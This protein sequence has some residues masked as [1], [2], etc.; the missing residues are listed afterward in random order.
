[1]IQL[2]GYMDSPFVRRVAISL[3]F[4]GIAYEHRE[5]SIFRDFDEFR[6]INPLVKV[7]TLVL[8]N[9]QVLVDS[10][11][12]IDHLEKHV[13]GRSLMPGNATDHLKATQYIGA[14]LVAM[15]KLAGLI[16]ETSHRPPGLQHQ[17][18]IDRLRTQLSGAIGLMETSVKNRKGKWLLGNET[19]QADITTAVAWRFS[20]HIE[21]SHID[22][23]DYPA[24]SEYSR[25]AEGLPEFLAC[26]LSG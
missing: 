21:A 20:Q 24:L 5:L 19:N 17:P 8:D 10:T 23:A 15:E 7:P 11:L 1:M 12:I 3:E 2:I 14:A 4:L 6:V 9:N 16:Y 18:W 25:Q 22:P 13:A 26:P